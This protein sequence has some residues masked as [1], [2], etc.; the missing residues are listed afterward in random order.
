MLDKLNA[1]QAFAASAWVHEMPAVTMSTATVCTIASSMS[2][3]MYEH[4]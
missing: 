1:V 4:L 2:A 3:S